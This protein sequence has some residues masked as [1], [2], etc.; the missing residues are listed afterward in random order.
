MMCGSFSQKHSGSTRI[1]MN[2]VSTGSK[3]TL[4][5]HSYLDDIEMAFVSQTV[6]CPGIFIDSCALRVLQGFYRV[7]FS[8]LRFSH[9]LH[10]VRNGF[11]LEYCDEGMD[12]TT[13]YLAFTLPKTKPCA[14]FQFYTPKWMYNKIL[15]KH[16][17]KLVLIQ[18]Q[19]EENH[20]L[21]YEISSYQFESVTVFPH[22]APANEIDKGDQCKSLLDT[23]VEKRELPGYGDMITYYFHEART[24]FQSHTIIDQWCEDKSTYIR[25]YYTPECDMRILSKSHTSSLSS[26]YN[27]VGKPTKI[28]TKNVDRIGTLSLRLRLWEASWVSMTVQ[29]TCQAM[30]SHNQLENLCDFSK[31]SPCAKVQNSDKTSVL[32][33]SRNQNTPNDTNCFLGV[34]RLKLKFTDQCYDTDKD[35]TA[36]ALTIDLWSSMFQNNHYYLYTPMDHVMFYPVLSYEKPKQS[37]NT[38]PCENLDISV[39]WHRLKKST[40]VFV[41]N[42]RCFVSDGGSFQALGFHGSVKVS[43]APPLSWDDLFEYDDAGNIVEKDQTGLLDRLFQEQ[44]EALFET[45]TRYY[46]LI[47]YRI[48]PDNLT[49]FSWEEANAKC[50]DMGYHMVTL[51]SIS[52][53]KI[54][55]DHLIQYVYEA[56]VPLYTIYVGLHRKVS[57][58]RDCS[59][60]TQ[61]RECILFP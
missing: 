1:P 57:S 52:E 49:A 59:F 31:L 48:N 30:N 37:H 45:D 10:M 56:R 9:G 61:R 2:M 26:Y 3:L 40:K 44:S 14:T 4:V 29:L 41:D 43:T 38:Q 25:N 51:H 32:A 15:F 54:L 58:E 20:M 5:L 16:H 34:L 12:S 19:S 53:M 24:M 50:E 13:L 35:P 33:L 42:N 22:D 7:D 27:I 8:Q 18:D 39:N 23:K 28:S 55:L 47:S 11:L 6:S 21:H 46:K 36:I 60:I 17:C